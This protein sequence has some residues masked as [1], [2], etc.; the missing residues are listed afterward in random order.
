MRTTRLSAL[1][2]FATLLTLASAPVSAAQ[3][4]LVDLSADEI[5]ITTG[6]TG[7]ELLLF[8]TKEERGDVVV[9]VRG[10]VSD[11][12]VRRRERFAGV[13]V[14]GEAVVFRGVP[15][16]YRVASNRPLEDI[17]SPELLAANGIAPGT[18][19]L[20]GTTDVPAAQRAPFRDGL[21]RNKTRQGLYG[22][23]PRGVAIQDNRLFRTTATF[24]ANVPTGPYR[25]NVYL[26]DRGKLA[27]HRESTLAVRKVGLGADVFNFAHRQ[28]TL[29]GVI[30]IVVAVAAGWF[31]GVVFRR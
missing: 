9:V 31:A 16:Y 20:A 4:L 18:V 11:A 1:S 15:A 12:V 29:Y 14:N 21:I 10:P 23:D 25:V 24:P 27:A 2:L 5:A 13:W 30:A 8:G 22:Y 17:A 26:F 19:D 28:A 7:T 3:K 6:F